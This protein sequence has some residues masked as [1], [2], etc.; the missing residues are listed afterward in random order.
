M[1]APAKW[2]QDARMTPTS[3]AASAIDVAVVEDDAACRIALVAALNA[4]PDMRLLWAAA[5]RAEALAALGDRMAQAPDVLLVDL[6][7]PDGSGLDV[8]AAARTRW[9][10]VAPMVSTIFGDEEHVLAAI[11]AGPWA[12]C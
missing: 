1:T 3:P 5:T 7:L 6:G 4:A 9:P 12:I 11:E 10:G 2:R 8:I